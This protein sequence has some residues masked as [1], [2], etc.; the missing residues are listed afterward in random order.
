MN[1]HQTAHQMIHHLH[2]IHQWPIIKVVIIDGLWIVI[3]VRSLLFVVIC[4][5]VF[6]V[7]L[8]IIVRVSAVYGVGGRAVVYKIH[9]L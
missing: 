6:W 8:C 5:L 3:L 1:H 2:R 7:E 4:C 9:I